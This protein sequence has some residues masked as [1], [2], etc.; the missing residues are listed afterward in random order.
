MCFQFFTFSFF[1][2]SIQILKSFDSS[3]RSTVEYY[4]CL[5]TQH[6]ALDEAS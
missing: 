5:I 6:V 2:N 1:F 4:I 3:A